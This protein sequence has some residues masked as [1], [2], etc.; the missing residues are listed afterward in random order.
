MAKKKTGLQILTDLHILSPPEYKKCCGVV[1][2]PG[3]RSRDPGFDSQWYQIFWAVVGLERGPLSL[4]STTDEPLG[5][6]SGSGLENW[7]YGRG[8]PLRW[9][10]DTLYLQKLAL[11]SPTCGGHSA[12]IVRLPTKTTE[13]FFNMSIHMRTSVALS[14]LNVF[15]SHSSFKSICHRLVSC[16]YEHYSCKN[17]GISDWPQNTKWQPLKWV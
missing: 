5:S 8:N 10:R 1:R 7:E 2:V 13:F 12:S 3:Y 9:P 11:T 16:D 17:R 14:Q 15:Y 6:S 4:V